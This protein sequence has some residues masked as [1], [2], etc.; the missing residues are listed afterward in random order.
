LE[1]TSRLA[2]YTNTNRNLL[3]TMIAFRGSTRLWNR[4][5]RCNNETLRFP[6][7]AEPSDSPKSPVGR[8]FEST[9][10]GGDWV[11]AG[12]YFANTAME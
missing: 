7:I 2:S 8:E 4:F 6:K 5:G 9:C 10:F 3:R 1:E 11:I 12:R